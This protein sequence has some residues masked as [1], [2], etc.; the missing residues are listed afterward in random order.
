MLA[1]LALIVPALVTAWIIRFLFR[2]VDGWLRPIAVEVLGRDVPGAG[3]LATALLVYLVGLTASSYG[4]RALVSWTERLILRLPLLGDIYGSSRQI[5]EAVSN[6]RGLGFDR[7]VTFEFPRP[8]VR[9]VGF[10]TGEVVGSEGDLQL[11]VFMPTTPNPTTGFLLLLPRSQV[12]DAGIG[13]D[14]AVKMLVSGGMV[15][16]ARLR[17]RTAPGPVRSR[18][19]GVPGTGTPGAPEGCAR[20]MAS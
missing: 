11:A 18:E 5:M 20:R 12:Q 9:A 7:V 13:V 17:P 10:V 6:T 4:I 16:P 2:L 8:G 1:G 3:L 14:D 15:L 19:A